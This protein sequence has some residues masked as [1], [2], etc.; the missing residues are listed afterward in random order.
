M[1]LYDKGL[2]ESV[3]GRNEI[4][5][6]MGSGHGQERVLQFMFDIKMCRREE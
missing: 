4:I 5:V 3:D 6:W 2:K 1:R